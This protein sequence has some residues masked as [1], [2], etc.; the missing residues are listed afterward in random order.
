MLNNPPELQP[1]GLLPSAGAPTQTPDR[2]K[3]PFIGDFDYQGSQYH[4]WLQAYDIGVI[5][6]SGSNAISVAQGLA[7]GQTM[8]INVDQV[9]DRFVVIVWGEGAAGV[10][11]NYGVRIARI[12]LGSGSG[13]AGYQLGPGGKL[14]IPAQG[15]NFITITNIATA[16]LTLHGTVVAIGGFDL[17]DID[18][19]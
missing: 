1:A 19:G 12:V 16:T 14:K 5:T 18:L 4:R 9:P 11:A 7:N 6:Y 3:Y 17:S 13:G 10:A 15:H 8:T 2:S